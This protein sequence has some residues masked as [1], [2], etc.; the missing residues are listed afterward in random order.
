[1]GE[2]TETTAEA[3]ESVG[4]GVSSVRSVGSVAAA[5]KAIDGGDATE[6][7][8]ESDLE[9]GPGVELLVELGKR[10]SSPPSVLV[11]DDLELTDLVSTLLLR[12]NYHLL[13]RLLPD[14]R[15]IAIVAAS[16]RPQ[17]RRSGSDRRRSNSAPSG[18]KGWYVP[19]RP[20]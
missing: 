7:V 16:G 11:T 13:L 18:S 17:A 14:D 15:A 9:D 8:C 20:R 10:G 12:A 2:D 19:T 6:L 1:M 5:V 3:V 4:T